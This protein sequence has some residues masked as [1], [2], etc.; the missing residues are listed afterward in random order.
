[1]AAYTTPPLTTVRQPIAKLARSAAMLLLDS[2]EG[3]GS[4]ETA[5]ANGMQHQVD[6]L[7]LTAGDQHTPLL[8]PELVVRRS[9][10]A[11]GSG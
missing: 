6:Q 9:T 11:I 8:A 7:A 1:M 3:V 4:A 10:S 5:G 2:I